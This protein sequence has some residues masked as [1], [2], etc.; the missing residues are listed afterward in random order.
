MAYLSYEEADRFFDEAQANRKRAQAGDENLEA[1]A[2]GVEPDAVTGIGEID[3]PDLSGILSPDAPLPVEVVRRIYESYP[4]TIDVQAGQEL[5]TL[6]RTLSAL[7]NS[8]NDEPDKIKALADESGLS[9]FAVDS[10]PGFARKKIASNRYNDILG[11]FMENIDQTPA[12]WQ[13][14][15]DLDPLEQLLV[16]RDTA[17]AEA[18]KAWRE[19]DRSF[20][21]SGYI[22]NAINAWEN[23]QLARGI[24]DL[25]MKVMDGSATA[26]EIEKL[27]AWRKAQAWEAGQ[28]REQPLLSR[29]VRGS[30]ESVLTPLVGGI[31]NVARWTGRYGA[32][33]MAAGAAI[34]AGVGSMAGG[35]GA[36]PGAITGGLRG[37]GGAAL[38]GFLEDIAREE[39]API[40]NT[41]YF[42]MD[43]PLDVAR[44]LTYVSGAAIAGLEI[45]GAGMLAR[46]FPGVAK[47]LTGEALKKAL[48]FAASNPAVQKVIKSTGMRMLEGA[49]AEVGTEVAQEIVAIGAEKAGREYAAENIPAPTWG[50]VGERLLDTAEQTLESVVIPVGIGGG[51]STFAGRGKKAAARWRKSGRMSVNIWT[52]R[53]SCFPNPPFCVKC[54]K[55]GRSLWK[56]WRRMVLHPNTFISIL[57]PC[58]RIFSRTRMKS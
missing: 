11:A 30:I 52:M 29:M 56:P 54:R 19:R 31:E 45:T 13:T 26:E 12:A 38:G 21:D 48:G 51:V 7:H 47:Y 2:A 3:L 17:L 24:A 53:P 37:L 9:Y 58:R 10:D 42:D 15:R 40:F 23:G 43:V 1:L 5:D 8:L 46:V 41:L 18:M 14:L 32:Q 39:G 57:K 22:G 49:A 16:T 27:Q 6:P 25:T 36:I 20:W 35:A 33:S 28:G 44:T 34:G 50:E 4:S 55:Q